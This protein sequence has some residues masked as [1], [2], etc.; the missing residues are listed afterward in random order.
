MSH[1]DNKKKYMDDSVFKNLFIIDENNDIMDYTMENKEK[2]KNPKKKDS[3]KK[4]KNELIKED[5][6]LNTNL[7]IEKIK[8]EKKNHSEDKNINTSDITNFDEMFK[9]TD[10]IITSQFFDQKNHDN[11]CNN[12]NSSN[13]TSDSNNHPHPPYPPYPPY[14]PCPPCP[15]YCPTASE[16]KLFNDISDSVGIN[17][18]IN[19]IGFLLSYDKYTFIAFTKHSFVFDDIYI[20]F[21]FKNLNKILYFQLIGYDTLN[22]IVFAIYNIDDPRN[23]NVSLT[24]IKKVS[25]DKEETYNVLIEP[26]KK[27]QYFV[28]T[29]NID[30]KINSSWI[31]SL[32]YNGN[33]TMKKFYFPQSV[34]LSDKSI[35]GTSGSPVLNKVGCNF[36]L[37][38]MINI[39][40][41]GRLCGPNY[42]VIRTSFIRHFINY[43]AFKNENPNPTIFEIEEFLRKGVKT[44][45]LGIYY[46]NIDEYTINNDPNLKIIEK[47]GGLIIDSFISQYQFNYN[48]FNNNILTPNK[49]KT[50]LK[51]LNP[52]E[53]SELYENYFRSSI[54]KIIIQKF[55]YTDT[56]GNQKILNFTNNY[57]E[58]EVS[59]TNIGEYL[60]NSND[61]TPVDV[62]YL[63][64]DDITKKWIQKIEKIIPP[65]GSNIFNNLIINN[66]NDD[67]YNL[68]FNNDHYSSNFIYDD[69]KNEF[70]TMAAPKNKSSVK[71]TAKKSNINTGS[72][73]KGAAKKS[74]INTGSGVKGAAKKSNI[75][76]GSGV[77]GSVCPLY[78]LIALNSYIRND[79][80]GGP[81]F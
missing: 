15:D 37:L 11:I 1:K 53:D 3:K 29:Y 80:F 73:V 40:I 28:N 77:K 75:N 55:T 22:D 54:Q 67:T 14:P 20:S 36:Y 9:K 74:N 68:D 2:K 56:F 45:F 24:E 63:Y 76:K 42:K 32:S 31:I 57:S 46:Y 30:K 60:I 17:L 44:N 16:F 78:K 8:I 70:K 61:T 5:Q 48:L 19:S 43:V 72:G 38:G 13:Q 65:T 69:M 18:Q 47:N 59:P 62:E 71:G 10:K 51:L 64:Y 58:F 6:H 33:K 41:D 34:L 21:Y 39:I 52:F 26:N 50:F 4:Y 23:D 49:N 79:I 66:I 25:L 27:V 81:K 7:L 35:Q 12:S